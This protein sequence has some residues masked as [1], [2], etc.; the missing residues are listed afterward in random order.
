MQQFQWMSLVD[1]MF[2]ESNRRRDV[3]EILIRGLGLD[4]GKSQ[5]SDLSHL[6]RA[7][8]DQSSID[9]LTIQIPLS[10]SRMIQVHAHR[11]SLLPELRTFAHLV[12]LALATSEQRESLLFA[13]MS[14]PLTS[15]S[16]RRG[17]EHYLSSV[18]PRRGVLIFLDVD[19]LKR[20]NQ[21]FGY[22][23]ADKKLKALG[24]ALRGAFRSTDCVCRWGGDEFVL[25]LKDLDRIS[26]E[27]RLID[28]T[29]RV[30]KLT[31]LTLSYGLIEVTAGHTDQY[32]AGEGIATA[33]RDMERNKPA[34]ESRDKTI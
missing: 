24:T 8:F 6:G 3:V 27:K 16:N 11:Q 31:Q 22:Q 17:F 18:R 23:A 15:L 5:S 28:A 4:S 21:V 26:A 13:S 33:Q 10:S 34:T 1:S 19:R 29:Q 25:F 12:Q 2:L 7:S 20:V 14:D 32:V 9:D 30:N